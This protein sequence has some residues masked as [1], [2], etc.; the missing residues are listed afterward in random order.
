[1][2]EWAS[3]NRAELSRLRGAAHSAILHK[4]PAGKP[5]Q[6]P[7]EQT[8]LPNAGMDAQ[9]HL[10]MCNFLLTSERARRKVSAWK[11]KQQ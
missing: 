6:Q 7:R 4:N 1:M 2:S 5:I 10:F 3:R 8:H 9:K 11:A